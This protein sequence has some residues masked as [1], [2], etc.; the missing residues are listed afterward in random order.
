MVALSSLSTRRAIGR[1]NSL[2]ENATRQLS[3]LRDEPTD[4]ESIENTSG[5]FFDRS[6]CDESGLATTWANPRMIGEKIIVIIV[7]AL[8]TF[9]L[10][11]FHADHKNFHKIH[12]LDENHR[13]RRT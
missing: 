9:I 12:R 6:K 2:G 4:D 10:L 7:Q 11:T 3:S 8:L 13:L 5:L 1:E